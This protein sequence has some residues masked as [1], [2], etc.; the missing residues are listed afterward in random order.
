METML[1]K[2]CI[3]LEHLSKTA[4][5]LTPSLMYLELGNGCCAKG[6]T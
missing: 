4:T 2:D 6:S 5:T 3:T 1:E